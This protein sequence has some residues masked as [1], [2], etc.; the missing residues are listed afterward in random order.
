MSLA[1]ARKLRPLL[2]LNHETLACYMVAAFIFGLTAGLLL[3]PAAR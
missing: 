1:P 3:A 2:V